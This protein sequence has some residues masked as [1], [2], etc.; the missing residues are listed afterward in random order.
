M[1]AV[2]AEVA[3]QTLPDDRVFL[4]ASEPE[5]L[6]YARRIS[7][8]RYIFLFPVFGTFSDKTPPLKDYLGPV[9]VEHIERTLHG[10]P[11]ILGRYAPQSV[12]HH[13]LASLQRR[14]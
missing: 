2:A 8:S 5:V 12:R 11:K 13:L 4:F 7:A 3:S 9:M 10:K 6:F 1:P 14:W